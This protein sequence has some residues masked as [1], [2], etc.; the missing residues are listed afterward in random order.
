MQTP[1]S[2]IPPK[3]LLNEKYNE[4]GTLLKFKQ[5]VIWQFNKNTAFLLSPFL[6]GSDLNIPG[7]EKIDDDGCRKEFIDF[8]FGSYLGSKEEIKS[9]KLPSKV[10]WLSLLGFSP[11]I[12]VFNNELVYSTE[13]LPSFIYNWL[14]DNEVHTYEQKRAFL[15]T[16]NISFEGSDIIQIRKYL[17]GQKADEPGINYQIADEL[18]LNSFLLLKEKEIQIRIEDQRIPFIRGIY[19]RIENIDLDNLLMPV[20]KTGIDICIVFENISNH[21]CF[22]INNFTIEVLKNIA[23][24]VSSLPSYTNSFIIPIDLLPVNII[25]LLNKKF[26]DLPLSFDNIN[27]K[28][29]PDIEVNQ[30]K[31]PFYN[32]WK[33]LFPDYSIVMCPS[34]IPVSL[35]LDDKI[36]FEYKCG[37]IF[38]DKTNIYVNSGLSDKAIINLIQVESTLPEEALLKLVELFNEFDISVHDYISKIQ[39]NDQLRQEW[40]NMQERIKEAEKRKELS[41][42]FTSSEK[43]SMRWFSSLLELMVMSGGQSSFSNPEGEIV[44][45]KLDYD[46]DKLKILLFRDPSKAISQNIEQ[47]TDFKAIFSFM[48]NNGK[49]NKKEIFIKGVSKKGQQ[50]YA[51]PSDETE[52]KSI[53]L[54]KVKSI[55]F[56]FTRV[57]DLIN[58]LTK[59][60]KNLGF[61]D[62][63]NLKSNLQKI[64]NLFMALPAQEKPLILQT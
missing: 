14:L 34:E 9:I 42:N 51:I 8:L 29:L 45:H 28:M 59:A 32:K 46:P 49:Q 36:I 64:F 38:C 22:L 50:L 30:W 6:S 33:Q 43:Y 20:F 58:R 56:R 62:D 37:N 19:G 48:D 63:Y 23:F 61:P 53:P 57:I 44:F 11:E 16:L 15:K 4:T 40:E 21:E 3:L 2:F 54:D 5:S 31:L 7:I 18:I 1:F 12:S 55:E 17:F 27:F 25:K 52:L 26:I 13:Q 60:F 24:Q 35:R 39:S 41:E 47:Y 10:S